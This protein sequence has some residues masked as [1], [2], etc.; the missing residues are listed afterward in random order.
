MKRMLLLGAFLMCAG[1]L[2][3]QLEEGFDP[4][5]ANWIKANGY[6]YQTVTINNVDNEMLISSG[7]NSPAVVGTPIVKKSSNDVTVCFDV[8]GYESKN[9]VDLSCNAFVNLYFVKSEANNGVDLN[10]EDMLYDSIVN[11]PIPLQGGRICTTFTFPAGAANIADFRV[12]VA[13]HEA[14]GCDLGN[15]RYAF[16]NFLIT[17]LSEVCTDCPPVALDDQFLAGGAGTTSLNIVLY[18]DNPAYPV[19][20]GYAVDADGTD[21]DPDDAYGAL[22]WSLVTGPAAG[23]GTVTMNP[24]GQ[25]TATVT[26]SN[27]NVTEVTFTYRLCDESRCDEATVTVNFILGGALPISL[28]DFKGTRN[29]SYVNLQWT[30]FTE[31]NNAGFKVQRL[32]GGVYKTIGY[33]SSKATDGNSSLPL[34][35][36]FRDLNNTNAVT[37]YRLVQ[38]NLDGKETIIPARAI[39]GL[40]DLPKMLVYPNPGTYDNMNVLFGKSSIRDISIVDLSGRIIKRWNS[41]SDDNLTIHGLQTGLYMLVVSDRIN[42]GKMVERIMISNK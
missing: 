23:T 1:L 3:A 12:F 20:A 22:T 7:G 13:T 32:I 26:R 11:I 35:Y 15:T 31:D 30:T 6:S 28:A 34:R 5:P 8:F 42:G 4:H 16:D 27:L 17:G 2:H 40:E 21:N 39:R 10:D 9:L 19:K 29:G 33:I 36:E 41:Y 38:V 18:G 14:P 25:G 37:W 24:N